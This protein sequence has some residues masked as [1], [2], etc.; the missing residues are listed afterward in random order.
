[1]NTAMNAISSGLYYLVHGIVDFNKS[2]VAQFSNGVIESNLVFCYF[3]N[4]FDAMCM[5]GLKQL[6]PEVLIV[7]ICP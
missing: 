1:M 6:K 3:M 5:I 7:K 4:P 2:I